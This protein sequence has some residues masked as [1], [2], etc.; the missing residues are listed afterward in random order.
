MTATRVPGRV[1]LERRSD[2]VAVLRLE[3]PPVNALDLGLLRDLGRQ[4]A[5]LAGDLP[6]AVVVT[7]AGR[8]FSAGAE[9]ADFGG[10]EVATQVATAF[11]RNLD[12]LARLPRVVIAAVRGVALG[13]GLEVALA[14]DLRVVGAAS[15]LG[16]PEIRLGIIPGGGGTQRLPRLLGPA[17]AK[18]LLFSGREVRG[19][20]AV[21]LG[22][23]DRLVEDGDVETSAIAWAAEFASG[24]LAAHGL[25][26]RAVDEGLDQS[27]AD[28][29]VLERRLFEEVFT[30]E[31]AA[32]GLR[33]FLDAGPGRAR[34]VG[35]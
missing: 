24:P 3:R 2:G 11:H 6:G 35:R 31:D 12:A 22:L 21:A 9:I 10:P 5:V 15:R 25:L 23:A 8:H 4:V 13:G 29:L 30:T 16:Q 1:T 20:E 34:F 32:I 28:G 26:K 17:R 18:E 19:E 14:C 7:G 27:L 33:S